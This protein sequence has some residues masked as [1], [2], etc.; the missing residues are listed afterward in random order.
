MF[1]DFLTLENVSSIEIFALFCSF[2]DTDVLLCYMMNVH[3]V[4][5]NNGVELSF[6]DSGFKIK[7]PYYY[8][9]YLCLKKQNIM[10]QTVD[11][12]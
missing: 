2:V 6:E 7:C 9:I 10:M 5:W 4:W 11:S 1:G 12:M 3:F 8:V